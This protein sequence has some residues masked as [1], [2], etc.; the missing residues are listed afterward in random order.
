[1]QTRGY[2]IKGCYTTQTSTMKE[3]ILKGKRS[4]RPKKA[5]EA[6][7]VSESEKGC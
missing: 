4:V 5:V 2:E 7:A 6:T 1:M 3:I